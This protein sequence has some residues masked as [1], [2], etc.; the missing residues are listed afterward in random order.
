MKRIHQDLAAVYG[1]RAAITACAVQR[2]DAKSPLP[3]W[4][5]EV[6]P[7]KEAQIDP[8]N[9][10][11]VVGDNG[12]KRR[13]WMLRVA[14]SCSR[15]PYGEVVWQTTGNFIAAIAALGGNGR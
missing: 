15:K 4:R 14:L 10:A 2:L 12:R 6:E 11:W 9:A 8:G 13:P 3:F 7:G 1:F 5:M